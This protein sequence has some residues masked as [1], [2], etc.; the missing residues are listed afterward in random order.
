M[1]GA[2]TACIYVIGWGEKYPAEPGRELAS[3]IDRLPVV[4]LSHGIGTNRYLYSTLSSYLAAHGFVVAALEHTDG[5]AS[6]AKPAGDRF[7]LLLV[8]V[9]D[10]V[11]CTPTNLV[12]DWYI[13][14]NSI[15]TMSFTVQTPLP[16]PALLSPS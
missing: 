13:R 10:F 16:A 14:Y 1:T 7:A 12:M 9:F 5:L 2:V 6:S 8:F 15:R 11:L 3:D 4:I